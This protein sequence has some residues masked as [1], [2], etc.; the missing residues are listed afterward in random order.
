MLDQA[1]VVTA[2]SLALEGACY[3]TSELVGAAAVWDVPI[4]QPPED[5]AALAIPIVLAII[6]VFV[7]FLCI[8][9]HRRS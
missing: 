8:S 2:D 7:N 4:L 9:E 3:V 5:V 1:I 6:H